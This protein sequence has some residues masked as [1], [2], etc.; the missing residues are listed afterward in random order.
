[1]LTV[2]FTFKRLMGHS[3]LQIYIPCVAVVCVS[4]ISLWINRKSTPARVG[5]LLVNNDEFISF[6]CCLTSNL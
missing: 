6:S 2:S 4:W 3:I 1:M 5:K